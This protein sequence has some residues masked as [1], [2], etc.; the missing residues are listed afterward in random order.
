MGPFPEP[1]N[2]AAAPAPEPARAKRPAVPPSTPEQL[3]EDAALAAGVVIEGPAPARLTLAEVTPRER[4]VRLAA[5]EFVTGAEATFNP[6]TFVPGTVEEMPQLDFAARV[7]SGDA[8]EVKVAS[9][10]AAPG[11]APSVAF[12]ERGDATRRGFAFADF[13]AREENLVASAPEAATETVAEAMA[14]LVNPVPEAE[15]TADG[16][17]VSLALANDAA[18]VD[19]PGLRVS[20]RRRPKAPAD[21]TAEGGPEVPMVFELRRK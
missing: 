11:F 8:P 10:D 13:T 2:I 3:A 14:A 7:P 9:D 4:P 15:P 6:A 1:L 19:D 20:P 18:G 17:P 16:A 21:T 12:D 5:E